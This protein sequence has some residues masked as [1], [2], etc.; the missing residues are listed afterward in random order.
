MTLENCL[1]ISTSDLKKKGFFNNPRTVDIFNLT[2]NDGQCLS[3][4]VEI[5]LFE[6]E[7]YL[8][9]THSIETEINKKVSYIVKLISIPSNI[10]NGFVTYFVCPRTGKHSR[11]LYSCGGKFQHRDATGLLYAQ[12]VKKQPISY[13]FYL[14]PEQR[15]EPNTKHFKKYYNG[16]YTKRYFKILLRTSHSEVVDAFRERF[17]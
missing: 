13:A 15:N 8:K 12:Q 5:I 14:T 9:F 2:K 1:T 17:A 4:D 7:K 16:D 10:G 11:K 3:V 6:N